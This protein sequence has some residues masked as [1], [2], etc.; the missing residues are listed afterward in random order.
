M[1]E[2]ERSWW[3]YKVGGRGKLMEEGEGKMSKSS[4]IGRMGIEGKA[5]KRD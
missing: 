4:E 2:V 1:K 5:E 3:S